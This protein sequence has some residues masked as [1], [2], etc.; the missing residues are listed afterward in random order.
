VKT[1]RDTMRMVEGKP[2]AT[3]YDPQTTQVTSQ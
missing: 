2:Q 3:G 1:I